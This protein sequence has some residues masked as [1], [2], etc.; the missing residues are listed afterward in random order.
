[1]Q[2]KNQ[3][4]IIQCCHKMIENEK[5]K[6]IFPFPEHQ[7]LFPKIHDARKS[8]DLGPITKPPVFQGVLS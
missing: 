3:S 1:M 8:D 2:D 6:N 5:S 7:T 4:Q